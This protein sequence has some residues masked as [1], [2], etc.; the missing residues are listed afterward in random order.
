MVNKGNPH[1]SFVY[2]LYVAY[3]LWMIMND[4]SEGIRLESM[5]LCSLCSSKRWQTYV[6]KNVSH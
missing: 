3:S 4:E 2:T 1:H 5:V 6:T